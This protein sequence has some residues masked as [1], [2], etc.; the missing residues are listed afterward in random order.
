MLFSLDLGISFLSHTSAATT[1]ASPP[2]CR[3]RLPQFQHSIPITETRLRF[4]SLRG[5]FSLRPA[6]SSAP[7]PF[8]AANRSDLFQSQ[9][10]QEYILFIPVRLTKIPA[11]TQSARP[12][13]SS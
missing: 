6:H 8:S 12:L 2:S 7:A 1:E 11:V 10:S 13:L 4:S 5:P 9:P 3:F